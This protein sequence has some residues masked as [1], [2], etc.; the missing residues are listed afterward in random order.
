MNRPRPRQRLPEALISRL[1]QS[2]AQLPAIPPKRSQEPREGAL[3]VMA[4][5]AGKVWE[6]RRFTPQSRK[7]V[8]F[9]AAAARPG[10]GYDRIQL[11]RYDPVLG[12]L[13]LW[14]LWHRPARVADL[15]LWNGR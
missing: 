10:S 6:L 4:T 13:K 7:I 8:P 5:T 9:L 1:G 12:W 2:A 11:Q 15:P 14:G 3:R